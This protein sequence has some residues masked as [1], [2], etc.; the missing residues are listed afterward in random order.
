MKLK[1][2]SMNT[3]IRNEH[4]TAGMINAYV[5]PSDVVT[6]TEIFTAPVNFTYE[7][8]V[9]QFVGDKW[10]KVE[11]VNGSPSA[12]WIAIIHKGDTICLEVADVPTEVHLTHT[13]EVFSDGSIKVDGITFP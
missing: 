7:G 12:G 9:I 8:T 2:I 4:N 3:R 1:P 13:I 10:L 11:Y 6:G 5:Q